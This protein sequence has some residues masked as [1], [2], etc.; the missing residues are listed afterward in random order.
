MISSLRY[1]FLFQPIQYGNH[2]AGKEPR[3]DHTFILEIRDL[4]VRG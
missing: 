4:R 1:E 3:S 2:T